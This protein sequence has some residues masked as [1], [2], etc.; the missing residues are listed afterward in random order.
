MSDVRNP[1]P[2][3]E[4]DPCQSIGVTTSVPFGGEKEIA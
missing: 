1:I 4:V 3:I 2:D